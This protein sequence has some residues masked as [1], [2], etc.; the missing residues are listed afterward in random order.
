MTIYLHVFY[1][2]DKEEEQYLVFFPLERKYTI[3]PSKYVVTPDKNV[4]EEV[5]IKMPGQKAYVG[6][7]VNRGKNC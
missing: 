2:I 5:T 7:L 6:S 4:G 3:V 1:L